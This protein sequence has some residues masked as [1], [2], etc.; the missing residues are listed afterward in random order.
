MPDILPPIRLLVRIHIHPPDPIRA[1]LLI[2]QRV[3]L[4]ALARPAP[5][6]LL[7]VAH[8][9]HRLGV[10]HTDPDGRARLVV[11]GGVA[12]DRVEGLEG[13]VIL[14]ARRGELP[15]VAVG[16]GVG[17]RG[18]LARGDAAGGG[19]RGEGADEE[20]GR[21]RVAARVDGDRVDAVGEVG[22][23]GEGVGRGGGRGE[24]GE[25]M[26]F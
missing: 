12:D 26:H 5:V 7:V 9:R 22:G 11:R 14:G 4:V 23:D 13:G 24:E 8:V 16:R 3:R 6:A 2:H 25:E 10:G 1:A 20:G 18:S 19:G 15:V 17:E 21:E